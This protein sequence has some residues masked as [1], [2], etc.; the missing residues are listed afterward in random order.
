[1]TKGYNGIFKLA[2]A[3]YKCGFP[4]VTFLYLE[5]A[6]GGNNIKFSIDFGLVKP[7]KSFTYK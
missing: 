3:Q 1:M 4:F 2:K 7:L 5:A 6:K